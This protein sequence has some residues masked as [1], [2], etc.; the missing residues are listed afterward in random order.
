[1]SEHAPWWETGVVYQ[2]Y[3][4]SFQDSNGDGVGDLNGITARLDYIQA[5]GVDAIWISP[6]FKSPMA[7]HGYDVSDYTDIDPLFGTTED[8]D[9]LLQAA[10]AR[11]LKV[12]L[13]WVP[14]HSSDEHEWFVEARSSK[15]NPYRDWYIWRDPAPDGGPPTNWNAFFGGSA[16]ELDETTG[17]YYLHLFHK[18]QPDL[19]W[20]NPEV[21]A[22]MYDILRYWLDKG[23]DGFRMDVITFIIKDD[24]F[25]DNPAVP[26]AGDVIGGYVAQEPLYTADRP[27][28]HPILREVRALFEEYDPPRVTIGEVWTPRPKWAEWFGENNDELHL[29]FNFELMFQPWD[30]AAMRASVDGLEAILKPGNWPSYVLGNHD[31]VRVGTRFGLARRRVAAMLLLTLRGTPTLYNGEEFGMVDGHVPPD[32]IQ[33]PQGLHYGPERSRD[34]CRTPLQWTAKTYAGFSESEPW[35]P[36]ADNYTTLNVAAQESQQRE[37]LQLYRALIKLRKATP[38]LNHGDYTAVSHTNPNV[39]AYVRT[40]GDDRLLVL[41]N[42]SDAEQNC[43]L[44]HIATHYDILLATGMDRDGA[45]RL[46]A[47][48]LREN[49]GLIVRIFDDDPAA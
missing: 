25:R 9:R 27:E 5:L 24:Q 16:W 7:D 26:A 23:V 35:L 36:I 20:R 33:D 46:K 49:E 6:I 37:I 1:M 28:V 17:Q 48:T 34:G 12:L 44:N 39:Y 8:F 47:I 43:D 14:N 11:N 42:F 22:A 38:A 30:A 18:K 41:L 15:D 19:N 4:R 2:I 3:P 21:K 32:R 31:Q 45:G 10:H 29:P 13:D 40:K